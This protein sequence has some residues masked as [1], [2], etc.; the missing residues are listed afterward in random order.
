MKNFKDYGVLEINDSSAK[1]LN[2]GSWIGDNL[3]YA[4]G[5]IVRYSAPNGIGTSNLIMDYAASQV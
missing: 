5:C 1:C 3:G 2:G 4:V